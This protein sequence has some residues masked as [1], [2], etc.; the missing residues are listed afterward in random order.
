VRRLAVMGFI[1]GGMLVGT[2]SSALAVV[3]PVPLKVDPSVA[4]LDPAA[5]TGFLAWQESS[6]S[7][8]VVWAQ[9][10]AGGTP[11]RVNATRT[12]GYGPSAIAGTQSII[13]QQA[14]TTNSDLFFYNLPNRASKKLP[15]KVDT[16]FWEYYPVASSDYVAFMRINNTARV[17][18]LFRRSTGT[19][20]LIA[21]AKRS[22]GSCLVPTWVGTNH[23]VYDKCSPTTFA[24]Q[25]RVL[26][27]GGATVTVPHLAAPHTNY[28]A[29]M[30]ETTQDIYYFNSTTWCG[31]FV[32]IDRWH[33]GG[34]AATTIYDLP[35]GIDGNTT[36]LAPDTTTPGDTDLLFSQYDCL[37]DD[38]DIYQINSVNLL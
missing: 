12:R 23:L 17:L 6:S 9:A 33:L 29:S 34:G 11:W 25:V 7:S 35:E 13:Y 36:S 31:L 28:G 38:S 2:A 14:G 21:S 10:R 24:C 16:A 27:I 22:C 20:S 30:D 15:A 32:S 8:S 26:T 5:T 18:L 37:A 19:T 4:A 3:T 1:V